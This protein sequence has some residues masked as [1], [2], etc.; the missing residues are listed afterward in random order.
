MSAIDDFLKPESMLTPGVAGAVATLITNTF[1]LQFSLAAPAPAWLALALCTVMGFCTVADY[2]AHWGR[3]LIYGSL[4]ALIIFCMAMGSNSVGGSAAGSLQRNSSLYGNAE[5]APS[6][7]SPS[8]VDALIP[9]AHAQTNPPTVWCCANRQVARL[10]PAECEARRGRVAT[11]EAAAR[12]VCVAGN[13][14]G[15]NPSRE[16]SRDGFFRPW[17][18]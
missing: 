14:A 2:K 5:P 3:K 18:R 15:R 17:L 1:A 16:P 9:S 7:R 10:P 12:E 6:E 8:I 11:S 13:D 4:N